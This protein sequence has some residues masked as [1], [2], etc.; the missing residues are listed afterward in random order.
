MGALFGSIFSVA[1]ASKIPHQRVEL[2]AALVLTLSVLGFAASPWLAVSI[3]FAMIAGMSQTTFMV[4]NMTVA[5]VAS[6]DEFRGRVQSIRFLIVGLQPVGVLALGLAAESFG[7][8][9]AVAT[10]ATIGAVGYGIAHIMSKR[11]AA[12]A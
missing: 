9:I 8:Q 7:P 5:Q 2:V 6:A 3:V 10:M 12:N 11:H 4:T 1:L